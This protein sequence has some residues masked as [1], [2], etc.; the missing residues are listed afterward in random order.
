MNITS[1]S[2]FGVCFWAFFGSLYSWPR[3]SQP[4]RQSHH[5][6]RPVHMSW[7]TRELSPKPQLKTGPRWQWTLSDVHQRV[8]WRA[9]TKPT[10]NATHKQNF[11]GLLAVPKTLVVSNLVVCNFHAEALHCA[12]LRSF[13]PFCALLCSFADLCLRS[14]ARIC[15]LS[16]QTCHSQSWPPEARIAKKGFSSVS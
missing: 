6:L 14:L 8:A 7:H 13:A 5:P 12:P 16:P 9:K 10:N 3:R 2:L 11:P 1:P 4:K 15:A